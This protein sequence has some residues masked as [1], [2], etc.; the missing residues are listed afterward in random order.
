[1]HHDEQN[2]RTEVATK[3]GL[4][5]TIFILGVALNVAPA[6]DLEEGFFNPPD[7]ARPWVYWTQSGDYRLES[8]SA[9]LE[10]MKKAGIG[11]V[12]RMDC[13][14]GQISNASPF[15]GQQW[16]QQFV[17]SVHEC[18]RLGLEFA[19]I[20]GPGWSGTGGPWIRAEQSMQHLVPATVNTTGPA[21]FDEVLPLPQ[22][23]VSKYHRNQTPQMQKAIDEFYE[24]VAV[25][26][27]PRCEPVIDDIQEKALHIRNPFTSMPGVR[28]YLP[29]PASFPPATAAQVIDPQAIID[30]T[31]GLQAD[32]RL[33]WDVPPG[34]WTIVRLGV[35]STG[36][37]TRPAPEAGLG[38]ESDK[39]SKEAIAAH[40]QAYFDPLLAAIGPR[41]LDRKVGFVALDADS[42][43]MSSQNWTP[44]FREE[45]TKRCG[46]D[47]WLYFTTYTGCVVGSR[48]QTE[49]FLW[50]VRKVCQELLLENHAAELK[51]LCHER[52]LRLMIESY[53]MN[54]A[55]DLDLGSYADFPAGEFWF[56][57][58]QSGWSCI[59]AAAVA[60]TMGRPV[61][62]AEAFT[63]GRG[64]WERTPWVLKNQTNWA[65]AVGI[66]KFSIHGYAHQPDEDAPGATFGP[67]GVF[68]NR[69][70]TFWPLVR[71]YHEY[72]ARCSHLLQQGVTVADIL[73][74]TPEGVPQVFQPP[75]SA[76]KAAETRLPDKRGYSFDGCSP[77]ILISRAEVR[78]GQIA[79]PG[80]TSYRLL[81]LP[82]WKT[83]TPALLEKIIQL[84]EDGAV[85]YGAPPVASP[86]LRGYPQC[87]LQVREL[88][89]KLWGKPGSSERQLGKGRVIWDSAAGVGNVAPPLL[90]D[91][92]KWIWLDEGNPAHDAAAGNVHFRYTL[93]IPDTRL[94]SSAIIE[95]TAD[96]TLSLKVN[97]K[98]VF[99]SDNWQ[100]IDRAELLP[101]LHNGQNTVE[102]LAEN[103]P[104]SERNPA[105]FLAAMRLHFTDGTSRVIGSDNT[106][107]ASRNGTD[108]SAAGELGSGTMSPWN[109]RASAPMA[110][111][112]YPDYASTAAV[113]ADMGVP[114]DFLADAPLRYT[115]RRT[116]REDIYF[117]ANTTA[118]P[119]AAA[120]TF[121]I[122]QAT[123]RL[124]D[125]VTGTVRTLPHF[126]HRE[127]T[128]LVPLE[129]AP[130]QSFFV[131]FPREESNKTGTPG[132][133]FPAFTA[134]ATLDGPWEV[135][136]DPRWGGPASVTF[137]SLQDWS[138]RSEEG[139]KHYSGI[140]TYRKSFDLPAG[141]AMEI[142]LDLGTV[143]EL[144]EVTLN[145]TRLGTVWCAPWRIDLSGHLQQQGNLLE[146]KVANLWTNR[147]TGDASRPQQERLT[148][149]AIRPPLD[150]A[151]R[152]S[153]LLGPVTLKT[154]GSV[155]IIDAR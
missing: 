99:S 116:A 127:E 17:H 74:L 101:R 88:A 94:L 91:A 124:W 133:N 95:A 125:A 30:L 47:P 148:R 11:G 134:I 129:L 96:N 7:A 26:A 109:L 22:P 117:V 152:P 112:L 72:I 104:S 21:K 147:L 128:T 119:V 93:D 41:P 62:L 149:A 51:K 144:A 131:I 35:R 84:V 141:A 155:R 121:R 2:H 65:F 142:H 120:C 77:R 61:V 15:L 27:F 49:R 59:E 85:V 71:D 28:P 100:Q 13:S 78:D 103:S 42:W 57:H 90:P 110:P 140:A 63:S 36:A 146:I 87:D 9:D 32:G 153:G 19:A 4:L 89:D 70:Q 20:T 48:E 39:F 40:F 69:K 81:V 143:H 83:M 76:L 154:P 66:N 68:W 31:A 106:W 38:L 53:D 24:D 98:P 55:G 92:G 10:A 75:A 16:R 34:E 86:S 14:V 151:L 43:E 145:G 114:E 37:N 56:D 135:A 137:P 18:E 5:T 123:P 138:Q 50:D 102:V 58:F 73:Y 52:G 60:H 54:P 107:S 118:E 3:A 113:L 80:G 33:S 139:I 1:M 150:G 67:Y 25:F 111:S 132:I 108:W 12:L 64:N 8:V 97:G 45:F 6:A 115:H 44:G 79:F 46:Y 105:G 82:R 130:H 122:R 126:A 136:F 29:S 23:R